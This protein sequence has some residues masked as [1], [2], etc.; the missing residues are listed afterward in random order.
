MIEKHK[1]YIHED[2]DFK[3]LVIFTFKNHY[4]FLSRKQIILEKKIQH[5]I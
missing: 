3:I 2:W 1:F 4:I 5:V